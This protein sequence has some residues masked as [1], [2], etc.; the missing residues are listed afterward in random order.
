ML[1]SELANEPIPC[2][3]D[4]GAVRLTPEVVEFWTEGSDRLHDRLSYKAEAEGW[5]CSRL[6][7]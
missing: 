2:P 7:P 5:R 3:E 4:W 1:E 6:A